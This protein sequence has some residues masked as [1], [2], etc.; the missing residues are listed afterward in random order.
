MS[1]HF[2]Q[3]FYKN[4]LSTGNAGTT[5]LFDKNPT[6]LVQG[7]SGSG[8]STMIDALCFALYGK[9]FR[10]INKPGLVNS[11]NQK[12]CEVHVEFETNGKNYRVIRSIKPTKFDIY[13]NEVMITQDAALRDYQQ[14]LENQILKMTFKT[15]TQIVILGSTT[16]TPFMQL[17]TGSRR[18][19]IE[20]IL[21]IGIFSAMNQILKTRNQETKDGQTAVDS[22]IKRSKEKAE[23]LKR[24]INTLSEKRDGEIEEIKEQLFKVASDISALEQELRD[25][26]KE[27]DSLK[28]KTEKLK[29]LIAAKNKIQESIFTAEFSKTEI[30]QKVSFFNDNDHCPTC[31]QE[32]ETTHKCNMVAELD[33]KRET[34]DSKLSEYE[35]IVDRVKSRVD[36]VSSIVSQINE[37]NVAIKTF[38]AK[39]EVLRT[40]QV[41]LLLKL[42]RVSGTTED[43]EGPKAE[44]KGVAK[45][46]MALVDRRKALAEER[47]LQENASM[48]LRDTGIK[49]AIIKEYLPLIN[50]WLNKYLADM[51][52]DVEFTLDENFNETVKSRYRD[53][54]VYGNFSEGEKLRLDLAILLVW[55]HIAK[56]K[57]STSCNLLILDEVLTGR[58]DQ[59]NQDI[60]IDLINDMAYHGSNVMIIAH[61]DNLMD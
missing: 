38:N 39:L 35:L 55:R 22:E 47:Q 12:Q 8:K 31:A 44:L 41:N 15:F 14:V 46:V 17:N 26:Q 20:D 18:E 30:E 36:D 60:V 61:A 52:M 11:V 10:S 16:Y 54:F 58:L 1:I 51:Q 37:N 5:I 23:G 45:N 40:Q 48:L 13:C 19:V 43:V 33:V 29:E 32:I 57:N 49:T 59:T 34:I 42:E 25:K 24:L 53:E 3:L 4:F 28:P 6:T 27:N 7:A 50:K 9:A 2:K 56:A 21:D